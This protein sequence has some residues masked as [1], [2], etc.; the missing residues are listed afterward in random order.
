MR[1]DWKQYFAQ[2][3]GPWKKLKMSMHVGID[4][5]VF[6]F[7][8]LVGPLVFC[9]LWKY[10]KSYAAIISA[11]GY[12][13][14]IYNF[15]KKKYLPIM[16]IEKAIHGIVLG[17]TELELTDMKETDSL[18]PM[19]KDLNTLMCTLEELVSKESAARLMKKQA[20]LNALQ[21]QINP[22]FLYNTLESIRGQAMVHGLSDIEEMT[23]ALS[24]LFRYSIS[25]QGDMVTLEKE[26]KNVDNY[27]MIQ[28]YRFNNKFLYEKDADED[29]LDLLIPKLLLQPIIENAIYH[30]LETKTGKGTI[31]FRAYR[32]EKRLLIQVRD[33]GIGI[34]KEKLTA[35]NDVLQNKDIAENKEKA[36]LSIGLVNVNE[37]IRLNFGQEYGLHIY[38]VQE[39]GTSV[40]FVLPCDKEQEDITSPTKRKDVEVEIV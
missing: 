32:T 18:Y 22:H 34:P 28:Q 37:R 38:S 6:A 19:Y 17:K 16:A 30:G 2:E 5:G 13:L 8:F 40:E 39:V 3:E 31:V 33:N 20:E 10:N 27:L 25:S 23:Q 9:V 14:L 1:K 7:F 12:L 35:I 36:E 21:S 29:T 15:Y 26:L 11:V 4:L 24:N